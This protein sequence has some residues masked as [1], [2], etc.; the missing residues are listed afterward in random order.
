MSAYT[1]IVEKINQLDRILKESFNE[2]SIKEMSSND[3]KNYFLIELKGFNKSR[4]NVSPK[5]ILPKLS[6]E[7]NNIVWGY[8]SNPSDTE[9]LIER[10]S[11]S[12]EFMSSDIS[13]IVLK[14]RFDSAYLESVSVSALPLYNYEIIGGEESSESEKIVTISETAIKEF[15]S[16]KGIVVEGISMYDSTAKG[17]IGGNFVTGELSKTIT[18]D[19]TTHEYDGSISPEKMIEVRNYF[20]KK[21]N[22][23]EEI[24]VSCNVTSNKITFDICG[25]TSDVTEIELNK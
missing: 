9:S 18:I 16:N 15:L 3:F 24:E 19:F 6:L 14:N 8:Y 7:S 4:T 20:E 11:P 25:Y 21:W 10:R 13:E 22:L 5:I 17:T 1:N 2:V 23:P 12:I